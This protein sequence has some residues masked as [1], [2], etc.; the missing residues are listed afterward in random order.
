MSLVAF[1]P[2]IRGVQQPAQAREGGH[3]FLRRVGAH[4][5]AAPR[6]AKRLHHDG[7]GQL[8]RNRAR[9][10]VDATC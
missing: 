9:I 2:D 7:I 1:E 8:L 5:P 4:D 6:Q 10:S 3:E